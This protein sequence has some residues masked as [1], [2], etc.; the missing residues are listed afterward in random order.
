MHLEV[1][2]TSDSS[3]IARYVGVSPGSVG[4]VEH[5]LRTQSSRFHNEVLIQQNTDANLKC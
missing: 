4:L 2:A 1:V 5:C 3:V